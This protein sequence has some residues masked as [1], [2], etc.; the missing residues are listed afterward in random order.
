MNSS[1]AHQMD[2][3]ST[4]HLLEEISECHLTDWERGFLGSCCLKI[5][6]G[7]EL[8]PTQIQWIKTIWQRKVSKG[9]IKVER[10]A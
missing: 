2:V 9:F 10:A 8:Q 6:Q 4:V 7:K 5:S 1:N 3:N